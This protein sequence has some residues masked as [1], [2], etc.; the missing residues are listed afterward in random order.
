MDKGQQARKIDSGVQRSL[1]TEL[2]L[3]ECVT[4]IPR[5]YFLSCSY[6]SSLPVLRSQACALRPGRN[7][8]LLEKNIHPQ[9]GKVHHHVQNWAHSWECSNWT[10]ITCSKQRQRSGEVTCCG[11]ALAAKPEEGVRVPRPSGWKESIDRCKL[12][13]ERQ[14]LAAAQQ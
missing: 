1:W 10:H 8:P 13:S 4:L 14:S 9:I 11:E 5:L 2:F 6:C 3:G 12:S 7:R